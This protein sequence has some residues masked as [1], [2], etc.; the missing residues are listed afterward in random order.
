MDRTIIQ[1]SHCDR[2]IYCFSGHNQVSPT[3]CVDLEANG[4]SHCPVCKEPLKFSLLQAPVSVPCPFTNGHHV[5]CAFTIG[6]RCGPLFLSEWDNSELHI[7]ISNSKG[8][9]Y[10]YTLKGVRRDQSGWEQCVSV[11]LLHP[12]VARLR[13]RWDQEL[14]K[15]SLSDSWA[16]ERFHEEREF[17]SCCYGFALTFI[18]HM[19]AAEGRPTLT[20]DEFTG[21]YV[22]PRI[23]TISKYVKVYIEIL[24]KGFYIAD[25]SRP[26]MR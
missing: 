24:E 2:S 20:R 5:P 18:N 6:S 9:V 3:Q 22:L 1:F 10:N 7:G 25:K 15:F 16:S 4:L 21:T 13:V 17:G 14:E 23:R 8:V 11:P 12:D 19:Q 26:G